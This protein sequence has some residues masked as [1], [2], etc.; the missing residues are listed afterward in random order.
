[1]FT[2][3]RFLATAAATLVAAT[4][5]AGCASDDAP[6]AGT[7]EVTDPWVKT[8]TPEDMMSAAFGT[9]TNTSDEDVTVV[10]ATSD[11]SP[12]IQLHEVVGGEMQEKDGGF[13]IAAGESLTLE[14]GGYHLMLMGLPEAIEAGDE[15]DF[16]LELSDGGAVTF[17]ATAKDFDGANEDYDHEDS[18]DMGSSEEPAEG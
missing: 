5:L 2:R 3:P 7:L 16:T 17:T 12:E 15:V 11:A 9:L 13:T 10:A 1:M 4:A 8:A 14:P 6:A 18:M